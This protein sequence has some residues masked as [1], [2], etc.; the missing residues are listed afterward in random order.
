MAGPIAVGVDPPTLERGA[1]LPLFRTRL[2]GGAIIAGR[3][4]IRSLPTR[5]F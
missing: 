4:S 1:P 5:A 2:A 3:H